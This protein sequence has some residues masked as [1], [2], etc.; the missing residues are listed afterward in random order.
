MRSL[1][2]SVWTAVFL[3]FAASMKQEQADGT[4]ASGMKLPAE[5][6]LHAA[7][8]CRCRFPGSERWAF[9]QSSASL[10]RL[11]LQTNP[12]R[13][14]HRTSAMQRT[15]GQRD[16]ISSKRLTLTSISLWADCGRVRS[17]VQVSAGVGWLAELLP[18][19]QDGAL[20]KHFSDQTQV[21]Q[22]LD[23]SFIFRL[24]FFSF[25]FFI[26]PQRPPPSTAPPTYTALDLYSSS[27]RW[28]VHR[29]RGLLG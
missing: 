10:F 11:T 21:S 26:G 12:V 3:L 22:V 16:F 5:G 13:L 24:N 14:S 8:V 17:G 9:Y 23:G 15:D 29:R 6:S 7:G 18:Q 20:Q 27:C 2:V 1:A 4:P 25:S 19:Q 28:W